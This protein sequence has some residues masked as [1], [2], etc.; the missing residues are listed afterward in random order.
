MI[1]FRIQIYCLGIQRLRFCLQRIHFWILGC[2]STVAILN[3]CLPAVQLLNSGTNATFLFHEF[4]VLGLA[5]DQ[6][7]IR[8]RL[9]LAQTLG[10]LLLFDENLLQGG[11]LCCECRFN[12]FQALTVGNRSLIQCGKHLASCLIV[13][14]RE[15]ISQIVCCQLLPCL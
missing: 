12:V 3:L 4:F 6:L 14:Q 7:L 15:T 8:Q 11:L 13:Q 10:Q 9:F 5:P 2:I 1:A